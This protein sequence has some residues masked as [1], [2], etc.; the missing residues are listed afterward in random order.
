MS[1]W[2]IFIALVMVAIIVFVVKY[3]SR[4]DSRLEEKNALLERRNKITSQLELR[5]NVK[6]GVLG[7]DEQRQKIVYLVD[8][9]SN[10]NVKE[11]DYT[12]V[13]SFELI[14]DF[15]TIYQNQKIK[16]ALPVDVPGIY[17]IITAHMQST[18]KLRG[19]VGSIDLKIV[20][21]NSGNP[22]YLFNLYTKRDGSKSSLDISIRTA[23]EW[24]S[25]I[26]KMLS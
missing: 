4:S 15:E 25:S 14:V 7:L 2:W 12:E 10:F 20:F 3:S 18:S 8:F 13:E 26:E 1:I 17:G 23:E 5:T 19:D 22:Y 11:F 24:A 6:G 9:E 16:T 21:R